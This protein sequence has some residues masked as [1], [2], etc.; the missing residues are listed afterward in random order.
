MC[1]TIFHHWSILHDYRCPQNVVLKFG[2][3]QLSAPS[4]KR[5]RQSS[6]RTT[7]TGAS[8]S[9]DKRREEGG[10]GVELFDKAT[11]FVHDLVGPLETMGKELRHSVFGNKGHSSGV[12]YGEGKRLRLS[13]R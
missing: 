4:A 12:E 11:D 3:T 2:F 10:Y 1:V 7:R 5:K 6:I 13:W 9:S 8:T